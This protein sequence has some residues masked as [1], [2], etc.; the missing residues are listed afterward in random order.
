MGLP[1]SNSVHPRGS[2]ILRAAE[3]MRAFLAAWEQRNE[4]VNGPIVLGS[5]ADGFRRCVSLVIDE[6]DPL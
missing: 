2:A 5:P 6:I 1:G 3:R 4:A